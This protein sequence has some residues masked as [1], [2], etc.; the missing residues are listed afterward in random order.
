MTSARGSTAPGRWVIGYQ[1]RIP[2][3]APPLPRTLDTPLST[4]II[5]EG[6]RVAASATISGVSP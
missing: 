3:S 1:H 2:K 5:R 4:V 6:R